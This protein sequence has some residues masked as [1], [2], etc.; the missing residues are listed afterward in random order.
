MAPT[1]GA[2]AV[3]GPVA[4]PGSWLRARIW[5]VDLL[6]VIGVFLYNL[7]IIPIFADG[8]GEVIGLI[9]VS[10]ALCGPYLMRRRFPVGVLGVM[11]VAAFAQLLLGAPVLAADAMLLLAV[12]NVATRYIWRVSLSAAA[13][14]VAWLLVAVI[15][16]LGEEV[17]DVGQLGVLIVVTLW[18]WTWGTLVRIRRQYMAGLRERAEQAERERENN[19][20]IAV[21]NERAR[22]AREIHDIVS[23]SLSVVVLMSD[24][25]AAKVKSEPARAKSAMLHVR[26]T[27][28]GALA[29]MRR[30]LGVLRE[31]EPGSDAPQP[32][33]DQLDALVAE[34]RTAG[35]PVALSVSGNR[36]SLSEGLGLTVY[37][38]VQEAL[39]NSRKHAGP[40]V[41]RVDVRL[42]Y[43]DDEVEVRIT[44]D[45]HGQAE[46]LEAVTH[47]HGLLGMRERVAAHHGTL[48]VGPREGGGF[49]VVAVLPRE[50]GTT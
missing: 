23:H 39:T 50:E 47:G 27:G 21:V 29:D 48:R 41:T 35:L 45:G 40:H 8:P 25:A 14:T 31:D 15:P 11:L 6:V 44:D 5:L 43:R 24:G 10:A 7:P 1:T 22:I 33:I 26:D 12:Y 46:D 13:L 20:R 38:L 3:P 37:R 9:V 34:S 17:I 19:A 2:H 28:R 18:V 32:G 30:M 16:H 4:G 42:E 36:A 49:E